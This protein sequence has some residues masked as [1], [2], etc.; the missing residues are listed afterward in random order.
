[1]Y[2]S[3][4]I[5]SLK[6][7]RKTY[8]CTMNIAEHVHSKWFRKFESSTADDV[9]MYN[10]KHQNGTGLNLDVTT[11][12]VEDISRTGQIFPG[13]PIVRPCIE[14]VGTE[15]LKKPKIVTS[16]T[17]HQA[18]IRL[19]YSQSNAYVGFLN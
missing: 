15:R 13:N 5:R 4:K 1:M 14:F 16:I 12:W 18:R 9:R 7:H 10:E 8:A 11:D 6:H 2:G 3:T 17:A 19:S